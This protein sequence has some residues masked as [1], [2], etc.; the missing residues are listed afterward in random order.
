VSEPGPAA[1]SSAA[2]SRAARA[3]AHASRAAVR[4][5]RRATNARGAGES[6]LAKL[7]ELNAAQT[8]GDALVAVALAG[9][10]FFS[11]SAGEARGRVA[12]YL[13]FTMVPFAVVAPV[14]GP[15]LDR[16]RHGRRYALALTMLGRAFF[17]YYMAGALAKHQPLELYPA[18]FA[19]LILSKAYGVSKSAVTPRLLPRG[20]TLV[21]ANARVSLGGTLAGLAVG[22]LGAL[23]VATAGARWS[24]RLGALVFLVGTVFAL[25]LPQHADSAEGEEPLRAAATRPL[26]VG[27]RD[28]SRP[29][30]ADTDAPWWLDEPPPAPPAAPVP[31]SPFSFRAALT[32]MQRGLGPAVIAALRAIAA[33]RFY[34]GFLTIFIAFLVRTHDFGLKPNLALGFFALAA[35]GASV[36][37]TLI[38]TQVHGRAPAT[39]LFLGLTS[40]T[41]VSFAAGIVFSLATVLLVAVAAGIGQTIGKLASDATIQLHVPEE[42]RSAAFARSETI[43]QMAFVLGGAV[44]LLPIGG[45]FGLLAAGVV[46]TVVLLD[47]IRR[48]ALR[49]HA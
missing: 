14:I 39:L 7:I 15:V 40:V 48:R 12:L 44:G 38:G 34:S 36:V 18:A 43:Q 19:I 45:R 26:S 8:A 23:I 9:T 30:P 17:C 29:R 41:A 11:V 4:R 10:L 6:G 47:T 32:G 20:A 3:S 27:T 42:I 33:L 25:R 22:A 1:E 21:Q 2:L 46:M 24:L 31:R 28:A 16:F 35:G 49:A 5:I 13:L 37:G